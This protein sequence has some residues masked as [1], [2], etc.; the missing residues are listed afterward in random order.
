MYASCRGIISSDRDFM[1]VGCVPLRSPGPGNRI[2]Y[3][4]TPTRSEEE[5]L[6]RFWKT[7]TVPIE[8][9]TNALT[10]LHFIEQLQVPKAQIPFV[11]SRTFY[12]PSEV[13]VVTIGLYYERSERSG[14]SRALMTD[15][16]FGFQEITDSDSPPRYDDD[17]IKTVKSERI[18][19]ARWPGSVSTGWK[20]SGR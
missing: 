14:A 5:L 12:A 9:S 1:V 19:P 3:P 10:V 16:T 4:A 18:T 15:S 20:L 8:T 11:T 13:P 6:P 2:V 17:H 7:T